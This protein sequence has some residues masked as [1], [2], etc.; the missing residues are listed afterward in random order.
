MGIKGCSR[1]VESTART[2]ASRIGD[3]PIKVVRLLNIGRR[4]RIMF[5]VVVIPRIQCK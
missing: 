5:K 1:I 4:I 2:N 3:N